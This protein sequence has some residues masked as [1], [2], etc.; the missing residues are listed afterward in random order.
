MK[1]GEIL[2][3]LLGEILLILLGEILPEGWGEFYL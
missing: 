2:L 1:I 3:I